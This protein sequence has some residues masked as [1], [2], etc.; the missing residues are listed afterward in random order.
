MDPNIGMT[1]FLSITQCH[2]AK[3]IKTVEISLFNHP[4]VN[5][6]VR[7]SNVDSMYIWTV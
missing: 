2:S 1:V 5:A 6:H 7:V 3:E 4:M